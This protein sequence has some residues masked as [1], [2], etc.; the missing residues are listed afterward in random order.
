MLYNTQWF[1]EGSAKNEELKTFINELP[2]TVTLVFLEEKVD[3]RQKRLLDRVK[4]RG[5]YLKLNRQSTDTL[6]KWVQQRAKRLGFELDPTIL[7][8]LIERH[9][10]RLYALDQELKKFALYLQAHHETYLSA[11][12]VDLLSKPDISGR[13]FD[14]ADHLINGQIQAA[15]ELLNRLLDQPQPVLLLLS[16]LSRQTKQLLLARQINDRQKLAAHLQ[17]SPYIATRLQKQASRLPEEQWL[18]LYEACF[19]T[20]WSIKR[21]GVPERLGLEL[22]LGYFA[23]PP[24][25]V[26]K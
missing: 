19:Q 24:K 10:Q 1:E 7:P 8:S 9:E 5:L 23:D 25:L 17:I 2:D 4:E 18:A 16:L 11:E 21:G 26:L 13:V 6:I 20:D 14:L 3:G 15:Y 12:K 22:L